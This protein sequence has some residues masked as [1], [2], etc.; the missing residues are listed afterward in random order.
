MATSTLRHMF[1]PH[2]RSPRPLTSPRS[3][4]SRT[5]SGAGVEPACRGAQR[6]RTRCE[7]LH[8]RARRA[9]QAREAQPQLRARAGT[10]QEQYFPHMIKD[11]HGTLTAPRLDNET[12]TKIE[13]D[14]LRLSIGFTSLGHRARLIAVSAPL[15][16]NNPRRCRSRSPETNARVIFSWAVL[17]DAGATEREVELAR[18]VVLS[19]LKQSGKR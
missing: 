17:E 12:Q 4:T 19:T 11:R 7:R 14:Q 10:Q 13:T 15:L 1:S 18:W 3:P 2:C 5:E 9:L 6:T 16:S 8:H